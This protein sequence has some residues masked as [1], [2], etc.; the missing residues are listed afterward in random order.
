M[1]NNKA[2]GW[3][4]GCAGLLLSLGVARAQAGMGESTS[5]EPICKDAGV[6]VS[7]A[8]ASTALDKNA[9]G[10]LTG[11]ATWMKAKDERTVKLQGYASPTG[12]AEVNQ[13]LS[14]Q[15]AD[16]VKNYLT[17]QG[18]DPERI[19]TNAFGDT[20]DRP[21]TAEGRTVTVTACDQPVK[22][23]EAE[24]P[25]EEPVPPPPPVAVEPEPVA[26]VT[27]VVPPPAPAP[28][29]PVA[30]RPV[31]PPSRI[32]IEA[33]VGAGAIG[34]TDNSTRGFTNTGT[35]WDARMI[36]G[37]RSPIA[38][39]AAYVGSA[40][41]VNALGLDTDALLLGQG[42]ESN[43]RL[44][45]TTRRVQPYL[46]GGIGWTRYT[47]ERSATATSSVRA[48]DDVGTVPM[49]VGM[50][51][52]LTRSFFIDARG[53]YRYAFYDNMLDVASSSAGLGTA[54]LQT[55]NA[56]GRLGFEF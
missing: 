38:I 36:F 25:A 19:S 31:G 49:G 40:Q 24:K 16:A 46:F 9:R 12:N 27:V 32:G 7:F 39:E 43:L 44:N 30:T 11:L 45:L 22:V 35:S 2:V 4:A 34:F 55:W 42:A 28:V 14:E 54:P 33:A 13:K 15:R 29:T 47:V 5:E 20:Q 56:S 8:N 10:G 52:R 17:A 3:L 1:R 18:V 23:V 26:P 53:T 21:P 50:T 48:S 41:G 51:A 37:S 6:T